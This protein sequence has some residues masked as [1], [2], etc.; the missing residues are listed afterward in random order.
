MTWVTW[1]QLRTQALVIF[2]G[3]AVLA[4]ATIITGL[5]IR[6]VAN[7]CAAPNDCTMLVGIETS[8]FVWMELLLRGA[9]LILPAITGM[10]LGA[11]LIAREVETGTYRMVWTQ[12]VSRTRWL[13]VKV[14]IVGAASVL[15]SGLISWMTTWWFGPD[16]SLQMD[17]FVDATFGIRDVAPIGYAAFAFAVGLT[18]GLLFRRVLPAMATTLVVFVAVRMVV[19]MLV[20]PRFVTPLLHTG[21]FTPGPN[22]PVKAGGVIPDGSWISNAQIYDPSGHPVQMLRFGPGDACVATNSCLN[23]YTQR[24]QYQ[25]WARYWPFQWTEFG[26]FLLLALVLVGFCFWWINGHRLPGTGSRVA[27][28]AAPRANDERTGHAEPAASRGAVETNQ[29]RLMGVDR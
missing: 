29:P 25:P 10:F 18:A 8:N 13:A 12:S 21:A 3:L 9:T 2:G 15:A 7:G 4:V 6:N 22:G 11:P 28:T 17:K 14:L 19:Q 24:I 23:G 20:R 16:D 26:L 5:Q 27:R 1:R